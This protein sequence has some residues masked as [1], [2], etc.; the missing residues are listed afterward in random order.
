MKVKKNACLLV[1][2]KNHLAF[3]VNTLDEAVEVRAEEGPGGETTSIRAFTKTGW[4]ALT[5]HR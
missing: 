3:S 4:S 1:A 5:S 2:L